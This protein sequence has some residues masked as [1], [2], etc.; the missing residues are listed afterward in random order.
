VIETR[1]PQTA[2]PKTTAITIRLIHF[3]ESAWDDSGADLFRISS[4]AW[5]PS[6]ILTHSRTMGEEGKD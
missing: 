1:H 2:S 3:L 4:T 6:S 5:I